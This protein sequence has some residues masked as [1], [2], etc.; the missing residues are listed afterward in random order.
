MKNLEK[1]KNAVTQYENRF[2]EV[3]DRNM[4]EPCCVWEAAIVIT[5]Q[6]KI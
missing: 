2:L 3:C 1:M 6:L 4:E 5:E